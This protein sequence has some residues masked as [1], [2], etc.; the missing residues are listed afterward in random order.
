VKVTVGLAFTVTALVVAEQP[1]VAVKVKV[2]EPAE[3]PVITP[4]VALMVA[5]AVL[6]LLQVP[7]TG[8][9]GLVVL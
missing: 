2:A 4:E 7:V 3:T 8:V 6:E 9:E 1:L 5:T